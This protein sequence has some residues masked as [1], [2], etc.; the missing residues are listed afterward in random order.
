IKWGGSV[1]YL[2]IVLPYFFVM[3]CWIL[4]SQKIDIIHMQDGLLA[5][6][7]VVLKTIFRKPLCVVVHG[8]DVTYQ[9]KFYQVIIKWALPRADKI[10]CIS[11]AVQNEVLKRGVDNAKT[12]VIP[13]GINDDIFSADHLQA[14]SYLNQQLGLNKDNKIILSVGRLVERKG[15][16]WFVENVMPGLVKADKNSLL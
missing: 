5:P 11:Q 12:I 7:G 6:M 8:L 1:L 3:A 15:M 14:R 9:N 4:I 2:P 16:H 10:I 13:L